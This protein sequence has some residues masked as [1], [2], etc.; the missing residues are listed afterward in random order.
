MLRSLS[1]AALIVT[2]ASTAAAAPTVS[3]LA[4]GMVCEEPG[5]FGGT[6]GAR[7]G[8]RDDAPGPAWG[9]HAEA[10]LVRFAGF[11]PHTGAHGWRATVAADRRLGGGTARPHAVA[12]L[13]VAQWTRDSEQDGLLDLTSLDATAGAGVSVGWLRVE[14]TVAVPLA[15]LTRAQDSA[16]VG[17]ALAL[18]V[19][20]GLP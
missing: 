16:T 9:A 12:G 7:A 4:G 2:T 10:S 13:T 8:V 18:T 11:G 5:L 20:V 6:L 17:P 14:L 15:T 1:I 19:G 3:A